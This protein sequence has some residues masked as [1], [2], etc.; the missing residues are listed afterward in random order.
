MKNL[1]TR[2]T[3]TLPNHNDGNLGIALPP[4]F[5]IF[6]FML[7]NLRSTNKMLLRGGT[8]KS[9]EMSSNEDDSISVV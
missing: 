3:S 2:I 4:V 5:H 9:K 8:Y 6:H 7:Q 1:F